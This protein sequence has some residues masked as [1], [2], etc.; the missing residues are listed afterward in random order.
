M[1]YLATFQ[2]TQ[3][4][5][6]LSNKFYLLIDPSYQQ[7]IPDLDGGEG[8][9]EYIIHGTNVNISDPPAEAEQQE[10]TGG[11]QTEGEEA[12]K[13][14]TTVEEERKTEDGT[15]EGEKEKEGENEETGR[16]LKE[17]GK[18]KSGEIANEDG[19]Q[20]VDG[21]NTGQAKL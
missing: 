7:R 5:I 16:Q 20:D 3:L 1:I 14:A 10:E 18:E 15:V 9:S 6:W 4:P 17:E 2:T 12:S 19:I 13:K 21:S 11:A 8:C